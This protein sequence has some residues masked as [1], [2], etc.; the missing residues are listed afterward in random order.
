MGERCSGT[1]ILHQGETL[2]TL[3]QLLP[4]IMLLTGINRDEPMVCNSQ[5]DHRGMLYIILLKILKR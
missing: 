1:Y 5:G 2:S 4:S 3:E